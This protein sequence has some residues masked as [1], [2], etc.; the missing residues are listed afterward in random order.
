LNDGIIKYELERIWKEAVVAKFMVVSR[1]LPEGT[2]E[3]HEQISIFGPGF[4]TGSSR[5]RSRRANHSAVTFGDVKYYT[6]LQG[7]SIFGIKK[8][9]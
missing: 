6:Y 9:R 1:H 4:E 8:A 7:Y 3:N 5:I 2:E